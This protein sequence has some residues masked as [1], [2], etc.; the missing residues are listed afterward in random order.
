[1]YLLLYLVQ[2][3]F[4]TFYQG[5]I[6]SL[7]RFIKDKIIFLNETKIITHQFF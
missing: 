5:K 1:M 3:Y 7:M 2:N 4:A 6:Q